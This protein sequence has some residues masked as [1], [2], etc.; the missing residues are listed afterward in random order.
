MVDGLS[1]IYEAFRAESSDL[2]ELDIS[3][4]EA[5]EVARA[6][7][8]KGFPG[9][10]QLGLEFPRGHDGRRPPRARGTHRHCLP[11]PDGAVFLDRVVRLGPVAP[12]C[13]G[14]AD[15]IHTGFPSNCFKPRSFDPIGS[16]QEIEST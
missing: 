14:S 16:K 9:R 6:L 1:A 5:L 15:L 11:G 12:A 8:R 7:I 4:D 10:A 13:H 3:D 2:V